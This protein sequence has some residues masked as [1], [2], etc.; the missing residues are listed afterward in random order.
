MQTLLSSPAVV[1][2]LAA[3]TSPEDMARKFKRAVSEVLAEAIANGIDQALGSAVTTFSNNPKVA[4]WEKQIGGLIGSLTWD[5]L[6]D[7]DILPV[8]PI[9]VFAPRDTSN[10]VPLGGSVNVGVSIGISF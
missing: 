7:A 10:I 5:R 1:A 6:G 2:A 4:G 8:T 9:A 3:A